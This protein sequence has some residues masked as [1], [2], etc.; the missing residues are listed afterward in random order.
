MARYFFDVIADG[1]LAPDEE[2]MNLPNLD[3]ARREA[4]RSLA[5]LARD[6]LRSDGVPRLVKNYI[7]MR[8]EVNILLSIFYVRWRTMELTTR[9]LAAIV[10]RES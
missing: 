2:G 9:T 8:P 3:A 6:T 5:E 1:E 10:D 4:S 7:R